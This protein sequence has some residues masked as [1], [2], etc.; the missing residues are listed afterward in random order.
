MAWNDVREGFEHR[1]R[2]TRRPAVIEKLGGVDVG[3]LNAE[4]LRDATRM[5][6]L[7]VSRPWFR[8]HGAAFR[9]QHA[10]DLAQ[11]ARKVRKMVHRVQAEHAIEAAGAERQS[12]G[13]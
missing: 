1:E 12:F 3:L 9:S 2:K 6:L 10:R 13:V 5:S 11:R 8:E 7:G 4:V